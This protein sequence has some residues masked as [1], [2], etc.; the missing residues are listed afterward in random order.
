M[1]YAP[2]AF[3]QNSVEAA[4]SGDFSVYG[5]AGTLPDPDLKVKGFTVFGSTQAAYTGMTLGDGSVVINGY[6]AVSSGAYFV[7]PSTF[8]SNLYISGSSSTF[9]NAGNIFIAGGAVDDALAKTAGGGL[10]W[11]SIG[12]LGGD[13]LGDH[14]ATTTLNMGSFSIVSV[15][16]VSIDA[17]ALGGGA[18]ASLQPL[19]LFANDV[20]NGDYLIFSSTR[21]ATSADWTGAGFMINRRVDATDM[22]YIKFGRND[23]D[24]LSFGEG[25]SEY[26]RLDGSGNLGVG[27]KTPG[28]K[29][30]ILAGSAGVGLGIYNSAGDARLNISTAA[31]FAGWSWANNWNN[32][33]GFSLIEEAVSGGVIFVKRG[34]NV[35]IATTN[36]KTALDVEGA[37]QFG[38]GANKSTF[39]A[40]GGITARDEITG[41]LNSGYA[42]LRAVSGNYGFMLRN[43]GSDTYMLLTN[44]GNPYGQWNGLRPFWLHNSN[45][46]IY[47]SSNVTFGG[48]LYMTHASSKTILF[49]NVGW[50]APG[51]GS[52]GEKMQFWGTANTVGAADYAL[53][54]ESGNMWFNAGNGFKWYINASIK[55]AMDSTGKLGVGTAA[56]ASK[57]TVAGGEAQVG[58][59]DAACSSS[60]AGAIRY[61]AGSSVLRFCNGSNWVSL[62]PMPV[63]AFLTT[64]GAGSWKVPMDW[65]SSSNTIEGIGGG[66]G[67]YYGGAGGG[68]YSRKN[69]LSLT[70]GANVSYTVG[71]GGGSGASGADTYFN[72]ATCAGASVCAKGGEGRSDGVGGAGGAAGSGVGDVKYSGGNGAVYHSGYN[73]GASG[74]AAGPY[75]NGGNGGAGDTAS[76]SSG[77]GGGGGGGSNG[78]S[79]VNATQGGAGGNNY[80]GAGGGAGGSSSAGGTGSGGGGGGGAGGNNVGG[81]AGHGTEWGAYGSGGGGGGGGW[82]YGGYPGFY[83]GAA[84]HNVGAGAQG[85]I[86]IQWWQ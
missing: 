3:A 77:G 18:G 79:Y 43:D 50:G 52:A 80:L 21:A 27:T 47:M 20:G 12:S 49:G 59:S 58:S 66:G 74:G 72:G 84:G 44:S 33:Q 8:A 34:G 26:M 16:T 67:G 45:A 19:S 56:P 46:D 70:P 85:I 61:T 22:G 2:N 31:G 4:V 10:A 35:G 83:G 53:G 5:M 71:A 78:S 40:A 41:V 1:L 69:N 14:V 29:L 62:Y 25:Q 57:L 48:Q 60:N 65:N 38:S 11:A 7:Q 73:V 75:G 37:I 32:F 30:D 15:A 24:L 54:I 42:Q 39:T 55:A 81:N 63:N 86:V 64:T 68:A 23:T 17:G 51:A 6:L 13:D 36:P 9:I 76:Y 82:I 28:K